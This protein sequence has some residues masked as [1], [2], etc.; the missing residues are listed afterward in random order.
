MTEELWTLLPLAAILAAGIFLQAAAGFAAGLL[1]VPAMLWAGFSI[2]EA[3]TS[4]LVA[5]IPQNIWGVW[6]LRDTVQPKKLIWPGTGRLIF[7]PIGFLV[8]RSI[9]SF[10]IVTLRQIVGAVVLLVTLAIASIHPRPR[11][12]LH[13]GWSWIAFPVSGFLQGIVGMGG[14]AMVFW[15]QAHDWDTRQM[16]GFLFAMYLISLA[17]ALWFLYYWF[18]DQI[19]RPAIVSTFLI[20]LLL[21]ATYLGLRFG[22]WLGQRRLRRLTLGILFVMGAAGLA[23]PWLSRTNRQEA[24]SS[25][26]AVMDGANQTLHPMRLSPTF[27]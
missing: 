9:E 22:T 16:R 24:S 17:P 6:S 19:I 5:T 3:Q 1:I 8:L 27:R 20:P 26:N 15:V 12:H 13:P 25:K 23:A 18:G 14:P 21:G 4:L 11:P 2:P 7:L 10:S